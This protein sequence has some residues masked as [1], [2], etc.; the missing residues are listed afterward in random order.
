MEEEAVR[1]WNLFSDTWGTMP[2]KSKEKT[3]EQF[4]REEEEVILSVARSHRYQKVLDLG[5]GLGK[6]LSKLS[7]KGL[8][9]H[10]VDISPKMLEVAKRQVP[11]GVFIQHD[12]TQRLP[13]ADGSFNLI[14]CAGNTLGNIKNRSAILSEVWRLLDAKGVALIGVYDGDH[15]TFELVSEYYARLHS[16]YGPYFPFEV[17]EFSKKTNTITYNETLF[18]HWFTHKEL[19]ELF[20]QANFSSFKLIDKGIGIVA[21]CRK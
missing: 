1:V 20:N 16:Y 19:K 10:G 14:Y 3:L 9:L 4:H 15:L 8:S 7:G 13:F 21:I 5:C 17:Q 11:D 12:I 2:S 18:S 6:T